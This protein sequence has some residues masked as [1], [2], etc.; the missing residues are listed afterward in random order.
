M[1]GP[2]S[3]H[4]IVGILEAGDRNDERAVGT[5]LRGGEGRWKELRMCT[6]GLDVVGDRHRRRG[7]WRVQRLDG[8][9]KG[10]GKL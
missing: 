5:H 3:W 1:F 2:Q 7:G 6:E 4:Q 9:I 8:S 10:M